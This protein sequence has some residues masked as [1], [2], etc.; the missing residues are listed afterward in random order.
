MGV[1]LWVC[2]GLT[3]SKLQGSG[4]RGPEG[5]QGLDLIDDAQQQAGQS[6]EDFAF[7]E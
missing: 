6:E 7:T 1:E 5:W 3:K 4:Q 2:A